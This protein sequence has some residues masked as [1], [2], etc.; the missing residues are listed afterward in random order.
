MTLL[1]FCVLRNCTAHLY[2]FC[3]RVSSALLSTERPLG[4]ET[5]HQKVLFRDATPQLCFPKGLKLTIERKREERSTRIKQL[6]ILRSL[7]RLLETESI[8]H[9]EEVFELEMFTQFPSYSELYDTLTVAVIQN[10]KIIQILHSISHSI[11]INSKVWQIYV[12]HTLPKLIKKGD[13]RL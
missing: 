7:I 3:R 13:D 2:D 11:N 6:Q 1:P 4:G 8:L 5:G 9:L 10:L 12:T